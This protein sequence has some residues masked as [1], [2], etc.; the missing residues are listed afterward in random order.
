MNNV[1]ETYKK[2]FI[3]KHL[4]KNYVSDEVNQE[5]NKKYYSSEISQK[6]ITEKY[7]FERDS[8][9]GSSNLYFYTEGASE[10]TDTEFS[11]YISMKIIDRMREMDN[12]INTI[13]NILVFWFILTI[14]GIVLSFITY[15]NL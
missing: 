6:E 7:K 12:K 10:I 8:D 14:I 13:K 2:E 3:K 11:Q 5:L 1:F 15:S 9:P 4:S